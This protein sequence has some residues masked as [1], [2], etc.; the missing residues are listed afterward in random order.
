MIQ[1]N[2]IRIFGLAAL[3]LLLPYVM[4]AE[5]LSLRYTSPARVWEEALPVGNGRHG[6]M[7]FG[8]TD[9]ERI[10]FN[11]NTLYSGEP[12]TPKDIHVYPLLDSLRVLL[13]EGRNDLAGEIM[14][15]EWVGR[16]NE[17][18]QPF[19]DLYLDFS[20]MSGQITGY[21]HSLD[22]SRAIVT[23]SYRQG[24]TGIRREVFASFPAQAIVIHI[25]AD[26]PVLSFD[27][28]LGSRHPVRQTASSIK[29]KAP[30]HAQRRDIAHMRKFR[31]ERLHP[32]YFDA[33]GNVIREDHVIYGDSLDC[34]DPLYG[35]GMSF[36][37]CIVPVSHVDG[38]VSVARRRLPA[39]A[40]QHEGGLAECISV[41]GCREVT[42]LLYAATS[43]N[44]CRRSPSLDG[45]DPHEAI[46]EDMRRSLADQSADIGMLPGHPGN[47]PSGTFLTYGEIARRH[48]SDYASLFGRVSLDLP[49]RYS[50]MP[51]DERI[52]TFGEHQDNG[53]P[54]LLFQYGRYLLISSSRPGGQPVNLQGLWN[55]SLLPPWNSG[56]TL[57]INLQMNYW[58][59][60]VTALSECHE[61]LFRFLKEIADK[62][63]DVARDMYGLDGWTI[64]HNVS[65]W[66]EGYPSDG[67][68]YWFFWNMS[69][70]WLCSHIWEHY[71]FTGDRDFLEEY[72]PV[73]KGAALF[74]S[75]WLVMNDAGELVTPV[76]T[77]P[78]NAFV[79]PDGTPA[80]VCEGSTMDMAIIRNLFSNTAAAAHEL[81]IDEAFGYQVGEMSGWLREYAAGSEGQLLEWDREYAESEPHHRHV[82]HLFG[83]Y[84]GNDALAASAASGDGYPD[85][86]AMAARKSLEM[87]GNGG[88]GWSMA[89][90]TCLWARLMDSDKAYEALTNIIR[91]ADPCAP[92]DAVP[93][94]G[95]NAAG[96][97]RN[98]LNALPFQIDGNLGITA[99]IS[100][101]L[102]QS[103]RGYIRLLPA[104][105]ACWTEGRVTGLRAR[106]GLMVDISWKDGEVTAT[107]SGNGTY[108]ADVICGDE[109]VHVSSDGGSGQGSHV[110]H[111]SLSRCS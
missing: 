29:G 108:D 90:K 62:G 43:Y 76:S 9:I 84:P 16:L 107:L 15:R 57:N 52:R 92:S 64:H 2:M 72:Y 67:F 68:V 22:L 88:T 85:S 103:H 75:Q 7:V 19:G 83:L 73:M 20:R 37:A 63:T 66:R 33:S 10:Q 21:E 69:G 32:E 109:T 46:L 79:L 74:C 94:T 34:T 53:L 110:L 23:T 51:T 59:A 13:H 38:T 99:G 71:L 93:H 101:M 35:K 78:E 1:G 42:F 18:Y 27:A 4:Q 104:L 55:D 102:L 60:E 30:A 81:G 31:T 47:I 61:P 95:D 5:D 80:S 44:G 106:G 36:E 58:P 24:G 70:P 97:Y 12:E 45:K 96:L 40:G 89:W 26:S 48:V 6:A 100:E 8:R 82:S 86:L 41:S 11:E 3:M 28:Y 91:Y 87:R 39:S 77:S 111:F 50:G 49:S 25:E 98:L 54:A 105:P 14:Q 65:I 56:Y 17:A